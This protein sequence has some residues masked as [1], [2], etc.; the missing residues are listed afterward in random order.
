MARAAP[1]AAPRRR[2]P[3]ALPAPDGSYKIISYN[4]KL[5]KGRLAAALLE[6]AAGGRTVRGAADITD[7]WMAG[8]GVDARPGPTGV[9][10]LYTA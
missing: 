10:E 2:G 7:I 6:A 9:L 3:C 5:A 4:S 8:G 1:D